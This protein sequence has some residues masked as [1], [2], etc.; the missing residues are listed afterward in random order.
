MT[1]ACPNHSKYR[2]CGRSLSH[3]EHSLH[4]IWTLAYKRCE[5]S[6]SIGIAKQAGLYQDPF[7]KQYTYTSPQ[8]VERKWLEEPH[9]FLHFEDKD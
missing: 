5:T 6:F 1:Q 2:K 4:Y 8:K 3:M 9:C 7:F